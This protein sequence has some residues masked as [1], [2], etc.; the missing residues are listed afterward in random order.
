MTFALPQAR[1]VDVG[2]ARLVVSYLLEESQRLVVRRRVVVERGVSDF[3]HHLLPDCFLHTEV[4]LQRLVLVL[5]AVIIS[6]DNARG[7]LNVV[8]GWKERNI[9]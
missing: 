6:V 8:K 9:L 7:T 4:T 2:R 3:P 1:F 5:R